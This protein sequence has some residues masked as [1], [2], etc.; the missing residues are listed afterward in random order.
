M[1]YI[2][3]SALILLLS[4]CQASVRVPGV[5]VNTGIPYRTYNY[6]NDHNRNFCP[7]GQSKKGNC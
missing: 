1:K 5:S 3:L 2:F 4:A 7:P 6:D